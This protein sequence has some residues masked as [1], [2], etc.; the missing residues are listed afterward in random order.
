[1]EKFIRNLK[2]SL[3]SF[4]N[5]IKGN[6]KKNKYVLF[7]FLFVW[8]LV[9]IFTLT[10]YE[11]TL[12]KA[13]LGNE[14]YQR[15]VV[16]VNEDTT[17]KQIL[18]L[19]EDTESISV[20]FATYAR[21]NEGHVS[22]SIDGT[23]S[24]KNYYSGTYDV[25]DVLDNI[26]L[27]V[28]TKEKINHLNENNVTIT[29][30]SDSESDKAIAVYCSTTKEIENGKLSINDEIIE[31]SDLSVK[32]LYEDE[33]LKKFS[34]SVI[35]W[36]IFGLTLT[37]LLI[38][39][40]NPKPEIFFT[41][42][43]FVLGLIMMAVINPSSPPDELSHYESV[44]G[45]S[46]KMMFIKDY[47]HIDSIYLK[48]GYM[49]G[50]Y[51]ISPGYVRFMNEINQPLKMTGVLEPLARD[52]DDYFYIQYIPNAIGITL[53]RFLHLNMITTFYLGRMTGLI[54]YLICIYITIRNAPS[55]KFL[56]GM[57]ACLPMFVQT[58]I[59]ITYDC[60]INGLSFLTIAFFMKWYFEDN[61]IDMKEY[62]FVFVVNFMLAPC[63]VLYSFFSFLFLFV[64][65]SRYGGKKEKIIMSLILIVPGFY[66]LFDIM[67]GPINLFVH[68]VLSNNVSNN[69]LM[70]SNTA[71]KTIEILSDRILPFME[72]DVYTFSY[73]IHNPIETLMIFVRTIRY[74]IKFWFYG[75]IGR[76]LSGDSLILPLKY[77]HVLVAIIFAS[78]FVKTEYTFNLPMKG[79][80]IALCIIVGL[81]AMVG[82]FVSWTDKNQEIIEDFGGV[83]V[84]GIQGRYFSPLLPYFF[85]VFA[86]KKLAL[87]KE[88]EKYIILSYLMLFFVI[89]IYVMSYTFVN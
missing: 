73:M 85:P 19:K 50:H 39:L 35:F 45:L 20:L 84:E 6:F 86:N 76:S 15:Y 9:I 31:D 21:K 51:N 79:L 5:K 30:S 81:Y 12:G 89:I 38:I 66:Q 87:P 28:K 64:P 18:P 33:L 83:L 11:S 14:S 7:G 40:V 63:K 72:R 23:K 74:K 44:L 16:Q 36:M 69:L 34:D 10:K 13:A 53:G 37:G 8:I 80:L 58:S 71:E 22:I 24:G 4:T 48:Y 61:R 59:S 67:R 68:S 65:S 77:V 52:I 26:Y 70:V 60:F 88:S 27:T 78:A 25:N 62:I 56:L 1:M 46:N 17:V 55:F 57:I 42:M 75:S 54:F 2:T 41:F 43:A 82:M 47:N 49:F 29:I 32:Y 3:A